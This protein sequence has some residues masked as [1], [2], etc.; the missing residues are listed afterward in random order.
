MKIT[1]EQE[2][3]LDELVCERLRDNPNSK[4]LIE[5]FENFKGRFIVNYLKQDGLKEDLEGSTAFYI[6]RNKNNDILMFFSLK[7]G[8]LFDQLFDETKMKA[9][10]EENLLIVQAIYNAED[11]EEDKKRALEKV[12]RASAETGLAKQEVLNQIINETKF[13]YH[14]LNRF[15]NEKRVEENDNVT[16]VHRT[17]PAIEIVHFCINEKAREIWDSYGF[18]HPMGEV[19]FWHKIV[20]IFFQVQAMIGCE[21][22]LLFA[23][24]LSEDRTLINYYNV[25]LKFEKDLSV[26]TNKPYYDFNCAFMC[27]KLSSMKKNREKYFENFNIDEFEDVV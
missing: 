13:K 26:G 25:S 17:Y 22:V 15:M 14:M 18:K 12:K 21:Y 23:A 2:K 3:T 4:E 5:D 7:C 8:E 24:D 9:G 20:P 10:Y 16:G 19:L 27:Q 11:D 1:A 6:V